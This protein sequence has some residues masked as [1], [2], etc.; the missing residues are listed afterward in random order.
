VLLNKTL[1]VNNAAAH[2][3]RPADVIH[4]GFIGIIVES[5]HG[6]ERVFRAACIS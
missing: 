5:A 2:H 6:A 4:H 1:Y 3:S